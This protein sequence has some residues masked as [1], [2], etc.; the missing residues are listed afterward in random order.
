M[1]VSTWMWASA[2]VERLPARAFRA[3][4]VSTEETVHTTFRSTSRS[5]SSRSVVERSIKISSSTKPA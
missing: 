4:P 1:P 2:T 5:S 3:M